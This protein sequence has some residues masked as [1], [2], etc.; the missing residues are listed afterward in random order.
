MFAIACSNY[1]RL[2]LSMNA[3]KNNKPVRTRTS[4]N[5]V[6][7]KPVRR[8]PV[9]SLL[10]IIVLL[11]VIGS[12][13]KLRDPQSFPIT[14]VRIEGN[15]Q[16]VD[17]DA[18]R[19]VTEPYV[20]SGFFSVDVTR[21]KQQ[22]LDIP[23]IVRVSITRL[24]PQT[25]VVNVIE[26]QPVARWNQD[27]LINAQGQLFSPQSQS[28]PEGI[29]QLQGPP[30]LQDMVLQIYGQMSDILHHLG[31]QISSLQ[32]TER[33]AWRLRLDNGMELFLGR[34]NAFERLQRFVSVYNQVFGSRGT[35]VASVD[36]RYTNGMAVRWKQDNKRT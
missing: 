12:W 10:P 16:H 32:L 30:G 31:L 36:L 15:L 6:R 22:L 1:G 9:K 23:W 24:W 21:L 5:R 29:P 18:L 25:L 34:V 35:D 17:R 27:Q 33:R 8:L 19:Q 28:F 2:S 7:R 4:S 13:F 20:N 26:Q 3:R 14:T 11:L